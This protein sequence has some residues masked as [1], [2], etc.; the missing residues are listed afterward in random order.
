[1]EAVQDFSVVDDILFVLATATVPF[2]I[3][4]LVEDTDAAR[5]RREISMEI[6]CN[7]TVSYLAEGEG[8]QFFIATPTVV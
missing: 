4:R 5:R 7:V 1:M 3:V 8:K 6:A 2:T